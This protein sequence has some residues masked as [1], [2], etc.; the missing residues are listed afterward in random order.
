MGF[1]QGTFQDRG[2]ALRQPGTTPWPF[3]SSSQPFARAT[4]SQAAAS[5]GTPWSA[6]LR[7]P[8]QIGGL[9]SGRQTA[10]PVFTLM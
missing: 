3:A 10:A 4:A 6:L 9:S 1:A 8:A 7:Q 2:W 5:P